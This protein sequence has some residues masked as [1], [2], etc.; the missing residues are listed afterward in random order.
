MV[1]RNVFSDKSKIGFQMFYQ[2]RT[3]LQVPFGVSKMGKLLD[4]AQMTRIIS[5]V[6]YSFEIKST[7]K[8]KCLGKYLCNIYRFKNTANICEMYIYS[9]AYRNPKNTKLVQVRNFYL[10]L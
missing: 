3:E 2:L 4:L 6:F 9:Y 10:P 8:Y 5:I 7:P 1:P